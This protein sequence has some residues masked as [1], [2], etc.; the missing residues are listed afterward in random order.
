MANK[1]CVVVIGGYVNGYSILQELHG[2]NV[3]NLILMDY[4]K[5]IGAKSNKIIKFIKVEKKAQS[6]KKELFKLNEQ[7]DKIVIFPTHDL[8]LVLLSEIYSEIETFCHLPFN[9][10]NVIDLLK[11]D[12]QY[13]YCEKLNIPYP[14]TIILDKVE[15]INKLSNLQFPLLLKPNKSE[16]QSVK[17][18]RALELKSKDE[19]LK[20]EKM[21][22]D[23]L[24]KK[25][26]FLASEVIPGDGSNIYAYVGYRNNEGK[27]LNEWIGKKISQYPND[28][29]VFASASNEAPEIVREQGRALLDGM[30][31]Y[32]INE[33]EFKYDYRDGK[34]KLMEVNLRSMMWHR[35]GNLMGVNIQYT[36][37]LDAINEE[38]TFQ[39]QNANEK[40][41]FVYLKYELINLIKRKNYTKT[42]INSIFKADKTCHAVLE[43]KDIKPFLFDYFQLILGV[44]K[45]LKR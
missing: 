15:D 6:L 42:F 30:D 14:K 25:V 32:G 11:K 38:V 8:D 24:K 35:I 4:N 43:L 26:T 3:P 16:N 5:S 1:S 2:K 20:K 36:Q 39:T 21:I 19:Y 27:I 9:K 44:K 40:I 17:V 28:F 22:E 31:L 37:Y 10:D 13:S 33:P 29:G 18:F 45:W 23:L 41:H 7:F 12:V 34:Y